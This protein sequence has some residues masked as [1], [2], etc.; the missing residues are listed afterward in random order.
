[1]GHRR[2]VLIAFLRDAAIGAAGIACLAY[3]IH[4]FLGHH[5]QTWLKVC[6][7]ALLVIGVA[8]VSWTWYRGSQWLAAPRPVEELSGMDRASVPQIGPFRQFGP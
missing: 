5:H 7:G 6:A 4:L 2:R 8:G 1:M 3:G